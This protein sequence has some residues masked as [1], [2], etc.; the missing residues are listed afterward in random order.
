MKRKKLEYTYFD[1]KMFLI[2]KIDMFYN[3]LDKQP[4]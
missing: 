1:Y 2:L 4:Y 3:C